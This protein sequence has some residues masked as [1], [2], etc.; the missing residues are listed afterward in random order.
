MSEQCGYLINA[1]FQP[2][3]VCNEEKGHDGPHCVTSQIFVPAYPPPPF[4]EQ[5]LDTCEAYAAD[6]GHLLVYSGD[7][8][9]R[10]DRKKFLNGDV[11][12]IVARLKKR[13]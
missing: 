4:A 8:E 9:Y 3:M 11:V 6:M 1:G 7:N 12:E 2:P 10:L 5:V 13:P